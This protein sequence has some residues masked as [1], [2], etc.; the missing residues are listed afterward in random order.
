M[1]SSITPKLIEAILQERLKKLDIDVATVPNANGWRDTFIKS[2][3]PGEHDVNRGKPM[4]DVVLA[5][6]MAIFKKGDIFANST[7]YDAYA[8]GYHYDVGNEQT[9]SSLKR[10]Y[11]AVI[12]DIL[13]SPAKLEAFTQDVILQH[14]LND[15]RAPRERASLQNLVSPVFT[16][17]QMLSDAVIRRS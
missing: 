3:I 16:N 15:S 8:K 14:A 4:R 17:V 5:T 1:A 6:D 11:Q 9:S 7:G 2:D 12:Q 10:S 13:S